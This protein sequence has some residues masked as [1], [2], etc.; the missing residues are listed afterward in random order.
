[1]SLVRK[2][3]DAKEIFPDYDDCWYM[4]A[5]KAEGLAIILSSLLRERIMSGRNSDNHIV[6][7]AIPLENL[8]VHCR[9]DAVLY[10]DREV[11]ISNT[12]ALTVEQ[13]MHKIR[14]MAFTKPLSFAREKEF[15]F[16]FTILAGN[17]ILT[18]IV[19]NV[20]L[21]GEELTDWLI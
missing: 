15:R 7:P 6:D 4:T 1:M 13:F 17:R 19:D 10:L 9:H 16:S 12:G 2:M 11:H 20:I 5:S 14:D 18:P 21:D 3:R 8:S